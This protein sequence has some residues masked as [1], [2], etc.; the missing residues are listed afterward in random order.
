[1]KVI[2]IIVFKVIGKH[3]AR[4]LYISILVKKTITK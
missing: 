2:N 1:M 4:L 3:L